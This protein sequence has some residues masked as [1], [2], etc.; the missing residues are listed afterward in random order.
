MLVPFMDEKVAYTEAAQQGYVGGDY[1][2]GAAFPGWPKPG[3]NKWQLR[4]VYLINLKPTEV[5]G[6]GYCY[7]ERIFYVDAQIW[8]QPYLENY[9]RSG[10]IYHIT[11]LI[12]GPVMY[13]GQR[14]VQPRSF[15]FSMAMDLQN[16]HASPDIG[17]ALTVD[18]QVPGEYR[19]AGVYTP[20]GLDRVMK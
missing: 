14:T 10:K 9:D 12:L 20:S 6:H 18:D 2:T 11:W 1:K 13:Q 17:Y 4:N 8:N 19:E 3:L 15:G 16:N 5:L 7:T